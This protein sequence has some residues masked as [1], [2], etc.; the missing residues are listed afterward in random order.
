[1]L[2]QSLYQTLVDYDDC[3]LLFVQIPRHLL[4]P[5][6]F[7]LIGYILS[8]VLIKFAEP[9]DLRLLHLNQL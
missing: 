9:N 3:A 2:L 4:I 5:A 6:K 8:V 1:M 7:S